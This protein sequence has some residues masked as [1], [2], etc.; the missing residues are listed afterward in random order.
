MAWSTPLTAASNAALTAAQWNA[1]VRDNF[2]ETAPGKA[3]A[4]GRFFATAGPNSIVE[5]VPISSTVSASETTT[6]TSFTGLA[7]SGPTAT[8]ATGPIAIVMFGGIITNDTTG[9]NSYASYQVT[10]ATTISSSD[11][12]IVGHS[13][14]AANRVMAASRVQLQQ[15]LTTGT[16][17]FQMQYRVS[18][19]IGS[20][21]NRHCAVIP[22]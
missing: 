13:V 11:S 22:F 21:S 15:G 2:A 3:T 12:W 4:A 18:G 19:G 5:R 8:T 10:G 7:S 1:S 9:A 6:S 17:N 16:N 14:S 20:F